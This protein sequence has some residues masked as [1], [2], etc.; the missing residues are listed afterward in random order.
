MA[1]IEL[2]NLANDL[3]FSAPIGATLYGTFIIDDVTLIG[4]IEGE[5]IEL[6]LISFQ[7]QIQQ[8]TNIVKTATANRNGTVKEFMSLDDFMINVTGKVSNFL[9]TF[10]VT[11]IKK[12]NKLRQT[13]EPLTILSKQCKLFDIEKVIID[14]FTYNSIPGSINEVDLN[15]SLISD[16]EFNPN[17]YIVV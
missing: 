14:N 13:K 16:I 15:F 4:M 7:L 11:E 8:A 3:T 12:L 5:K 2:K 1:T 10:P 6:S 9:P 17:D